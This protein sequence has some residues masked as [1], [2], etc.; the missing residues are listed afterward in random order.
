MSRNPWIS[1]LL[2][3]DLSKAPTVRAYLTDP[4][5]YMIGIGTHPSTP[6][7]P[8]TLAPARLTPAARRAINVATADPW[9]ADPECAAH[10]HATPWTSAHEALRAVADHHTPWSWQPRVSAW[11]PS[12]RRYLYLLPAGMPPGPGP[13]PR[14]VGAPREGYPVHRG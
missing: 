1:P 8:V 10:G 12:T 14:I 9:I 5:W 7:A 13:N 2:A 4:V 11:I 3:L 6:H